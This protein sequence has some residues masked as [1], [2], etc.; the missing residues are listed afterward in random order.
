VENSDA[1]V[2]AANLE[3]VQRH[4]KKYTT[5]RKP[6]KCPVDRRMKLRVASQYKSEIIPN[7]LNPH[8]NEDALLTGVQSESIIVLSLYDADLLLGQNSLHVDDIEDLYSG[9]SVTF[10]DTN[11]GD[12]LY[13]VFESSGKPITM[14]GEGKMKGKGQL[15]FGVRLLSLSHSM[16]GWLHK[17]ST[18]SAR[19]KSRWVVLHDYA[20]HFYDNPYHM[21]TCKG[22]LLCRDVISLTFEKDEFFTLH[23]ADESKSWKFCFESAV[24]NPV[25]NN[26]WLRKIIRSCPNIKDPASMALLGLPEAMWQRRSVDDISHGIP[27]TLDIA[28][29]GYVNVSSLNK[30]ENV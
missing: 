10:E 24:P 11:I 9:H 1:G 15:T 2:Y 4:D 25:Y 27:P 22:T 30:K 7:T 28:R 16:S 12:F 14:T 18:H 20:I 13:P 21:N 5:N 6:F 19:L 29:N 26:M 17:A 3:R 23:C 8:W